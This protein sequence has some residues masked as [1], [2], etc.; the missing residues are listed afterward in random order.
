MRLGR[1]SGVRLASGPGRSLVLDRGYANF[2][3]LPKGEVRRI[4]LLRRWVNKVKKRKGGGLA[5]PTISAQALLSGSLSDSLGRP[6][7]SSRPS[8]RPPRARGRDGWVGPGRACRRPPMCGRSRRDRRA[9]ARRGDRPIPPRHPMRRA[10]GVPR[11]P[12]PPNASLR[13]ATH[14]P[15]VQ[16]YPWIGPRL[17]GREGRRTAETVDHPAGAA[18]ERTRSARTTP[19]GPRRA[20]SDSRGAKN[21]GDPSQRGCRHA[22]QGL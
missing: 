1:Y 2:R 20:S 6:P 8:T 5:S 3:E 17:K 19:G 15:W 7:R 18:R 12:R 10:G 16:L 13:A 4:L 22:S 9:A 11:S 14:P 21:C